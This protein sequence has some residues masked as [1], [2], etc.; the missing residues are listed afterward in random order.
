MKLSAWALYGGSVHTVPA[1]LSWFF[2]AMTL[3][4]AVQNKAQNEIDRVVGH[5]RLPGFQ[6]RAD[7]P[8][9]EAVIKESMRWIPIAPLS[10][11]RACNE[12]IENFRGYYIPKGSTILPSISWYSQDPKIYHNP[13]IFKPERFLGPNQELDPYKFVFGFG[14][15]IC[16]GRFF[17]DDFMFLVI[18]QTLAGFNIRKAVDPTTQEEIIPTTNS[19]TGT[20]AHPVALQCCVTPRD[21]KRRELIS[22]ID[23]DHPTE[24]DDAVLL[25]GLLGKGTRV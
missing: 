2:L 19:T 5:E 13:D 22:S 8:Y 14:R 4:P 1:A 24:A 23:A 16:P 3:F 21:E 11:P 15:R 10:L 6:D 12:E 17:A 9:V 20:L 7:L 25:Q 18:A